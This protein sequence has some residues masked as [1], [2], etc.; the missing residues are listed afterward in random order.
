MA[1]P[2]KNISPY[3]CTRVNWTDEW[4]I[5][6]NLFCSSLDFALSS[7]GTAQLYYH[8]GSVMRGG[9]EFAEELPLVLDNHWVKIPIDPTNADEPS[10]WWYGIIGVEDLEL[11]G[12]GPAQMTGDQILTAFAPEYLFTRIQVVDTNVEGLFSLVKSSHAFNAFR[13]DRTGARER[14]A[15]K[16]KI[17]ASFANDLSDADEWTAKD[18]LSYLVTYARYHSGAIDGVSLTYDMNDDDDYTPLT[19][20]TQGRTIYE[21]FD[22]L[23]SPS[24]GLCWKVVPLATVEGGFVVKVRS[25]LSEASTLGSITLNAADVVK[26]LMLYDRQDIARIKLRTDAT[27]RYDQVVVEGGPFGTVFSIGINN[28]G[29]VNNNLLRNWSDELAEDYRIAKRT[30]G[31]YDTIGYVEKMERND[32]YRLNPKFAEV[33]KSYKLRNDFDRRTE[34]SGVLKSILFP[35]YTNASVL[36]YRGLAEDAQEQWVS[37][38]RVQPYVALHEDVDYSAGDFLD[39]HTASL[40][41]YRLVPMYIKDVGGRWANVRQIQNSVLDDETINFKFSGA[42]QPHDNSLGVNF[43]MNVLPHCLQSVYSFDGIQAPADSSL[44]HVNRK[45]GF[46]YNVAATVY[47]HSSHNVRVTYPEEIEEVP[48]NLTSILVIRLG[49]QA[50]IDAVAVDTIVGVDEQTH[51]LLYVDSDGTLRDDRPKMLQLAARAY[52]WYQKPRAS[53]DATF[54]SIFNDFEIGDVISRLTFG[55]PTFLRNSN[56]EII[57]L[58]GI[59]TPD[60]VS[61]ELI[62]T[63]EGAVFLTSDGNLLGTGVDSVT[64]G[65]TIPGSKLLID[66]ES[67]RYVNT[68]VSRITYD[69]IA[70]STRIETQYQEV[71]LAGLFGDG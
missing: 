65:T 28:D 43:E 9:G 14:F 34:R 22:E 15:N 29:A 62:G 51:G 2:A 48:G 6:P 68:V 60:I 21:I 56:N 53:L 1:A 36:G 41:N 70:F 45:D 23:F 16:S 63:P 54:A 17:Q 24:R 52:S 40:A 7:I 61:H 47:V 42:V 18:I 71:N 8:F 39:K 30:D 13:S 49:R 5:R 25:I 37:A 35:G 50:R 27:R 67:S 32:A 3:V 66:N 12:P 38:M 59:T 31:D 46:A 26:P 19:I 55:K 11:R 10:R 20:E 57:T 33:Y 4:T 58:D 64:P 69:F 44:S